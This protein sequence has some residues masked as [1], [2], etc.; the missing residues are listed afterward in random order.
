MK[1]FSSLL[2][3]DWRS[4]SLSSSAPKLTLFPRGWS[5]AE[6]ELFLLVRWK[7]SQNSS[8]HEWNKIVFCCQRVDEFSSHFNYLINIYKNKDI[9]VVSALFN[10]SNTKWREATERGTATR[11]IPILNQSL[12]VCGLWP[13]SVGLLTPGERKPR[14]C[15]IVWMG[16]SLDSNVAVIT[17]KKKCA[18]A[19]VGNMASSLSD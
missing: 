16:D 8:E 2:I 3:A 5:H 15:R 12:Q 14:N 4:F 13:S 19:P 11:N 17:M 10:Y 18:Y 1:F 7:C 6:I 9:K